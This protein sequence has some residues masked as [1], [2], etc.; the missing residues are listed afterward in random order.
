MLVSDRPL[1]T[2]GSP[3][4]YGIVYIRDENVPVGAVNPVMFTGTGGP[5]FY[6]AV[7]L[8]GSST[9]NGG[10]QIIFNKTTLQN[11]YNSPKFMRYGAVPG[12]WSDSVR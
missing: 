1:V 6:G 9:I 5:Q 10:P 4:F 11:I 8:E 2:N 3:T 12:S 7:L